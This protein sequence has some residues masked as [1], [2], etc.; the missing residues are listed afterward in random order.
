M[1]NPDGQSRSATGL[2]LVA[3][4]A[5]ALILLGVLFAL[6]GWWNVLFR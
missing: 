6:L 2:I 1:P 5:L 3:G 4:L